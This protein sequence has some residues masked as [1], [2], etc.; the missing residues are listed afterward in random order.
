MWTNIEYVTLVEYMTGG[1]AAD[2]RL[3]LKNFHSC[4]KFGRPKGSA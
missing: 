3:G 1:H 2:E 4:S